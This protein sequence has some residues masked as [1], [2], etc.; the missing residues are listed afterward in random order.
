MSPKFP[1]FILFFF[2]SN[3]PFWLAHHEQKK[4]PKINKSLKLWKVPKIEVSMWRCGASCLADLYMRE[5]R[6]FGQTIWD[7]SVV[8]LGIS[9]GNTLKTCESTMGTWSEHKKRKKVPNKPAPKGKKRSLLECMFNNLIG[10]MQNLF[11][12]LMSSFLA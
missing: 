5:G 1:Y 12:K 6:N 7:E 8:L 11:L 4:N 9:L 3:E 2:G 10:Y